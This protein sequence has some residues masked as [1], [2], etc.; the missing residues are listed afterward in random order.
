M[1]KI[2]QILILV[3]IEMIA[4]IIKL[5]MLKPFVRHNKNSINNSKKMVDEI[6]KPIISITMTNIIA[7][8]I[9]NK[10]E[11]NDPFEGHI[12]LTSSNLIKRIFLKKMHEEKNI[13][14]HDSI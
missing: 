11:F 4:T 8:K 13:N 12:F 7:I 6:I 5:L 2:N 14:K 10:T 3:H 9:A 1:L